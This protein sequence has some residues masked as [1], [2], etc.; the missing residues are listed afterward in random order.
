[1]SKSGFHYTVRELTAEVSL[2]EYLRDC[3]D[4]PRF[5][6]CCKA[7]HNY[8]AGWSCPPYTFNP[9][10]LWN[11]YARLRIYTRM[12]IGNESGQTP[13]S[14]LQ[15]LE[16]EKDVYLHTLL[17]WESAAPG[18]LALAA[19]S[20]TLCI[21]C[22]RKNGQPCRKPEQMRYSIES[23]GGDVGLTALRYLGYPLLW[24]KD[25]ILP[26]YLMLVGALL[27]PDKKVE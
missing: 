8:G 2:A 3:V 1:M 12:L 27:L 7:C 22:A 6:S 17:S 21:P 16:E 5:L 15:A 19:G 4:V 11:R 13:Q 20:C 18:S 14:A 26:D 24:I 23:L 25:G 9:M 10:E